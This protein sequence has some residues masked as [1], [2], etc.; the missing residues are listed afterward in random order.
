[1]YG[2]CVCVLLHFVQVV[3][4]NSCVASLTLSA[5][6]NRR[7]ATKEDNLWTTFGAY[8]SVELSFR[9][10]L[11]HHAQANTASEQAVTVSDYY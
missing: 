11:N 3:I 6:F 10:F 7:R 4:P 5:R 1:M 8:L 2:G 9:H